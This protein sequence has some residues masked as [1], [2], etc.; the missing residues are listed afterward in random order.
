MDELEKIRKEKMKKLLEKQETNTIIEVDDK[1]F[2]EKV[3]KQS[4]EIPVVVDFWSTWCM[5][6][7]ALGPILEKLAKEYDGK[8]VLAKINVDEGR[9]TAQE[10]GIMSIPNI[11]LFKN[12][13][14]IDEFIGLLPESAVRQWLDKNLK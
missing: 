14:V 7:L 13:K 5:P 12:G 10:H 4:K 8:F 11:K 9:E 2:K 1:N 3:I 6:C